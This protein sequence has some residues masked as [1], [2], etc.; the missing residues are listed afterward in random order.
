MNLGVTVIEIRHFHLC[1]GLGGGARGFNR[2]RAQIGSLPPGSGASAVLMSIRMQ[3]RISKD[4][5]APAARCW[6]CSTASSITTSMEL[7]RA[8]LARGNAGRIRRAA[9]NE[10]PHI[11]FGSCPCK[12]FSGLL[13]EDKSRSRKY[14]ALNR[15]ALG[16]VWLT[17]EAGRTILRS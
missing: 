16:A 4:S 7:S 9:G 1:C 8:A 10:R 5:R 11:V 3:L 12:G 2:G 15:L 13:P 6:I 17:L 14:Q